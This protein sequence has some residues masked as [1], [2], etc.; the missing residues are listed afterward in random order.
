MAKV[1]KFRVCLGE[2]EDFIWRDIEISSMSSVAKF[3]YAILASFSAVGSHLFGITVHG[4]RYEFSLDDDDFEDGFEE[5]IPPSVVKLASLNLQCG[6]TFAM[7]YD[8]GAGWEFA[9]TLTEASTME[10]GTG[11]RYPHI[12]DGKGN[13]LIEDASPGE[14]LEYIKETDQTGEPPIYYDGYMDC[15]RTWDYREFDAKAL[16]ASFKG[17]I[18]ALQKAYESDSWE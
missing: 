12:T 10:K 13:G 8:Y 6:D 14:L 16:N 9:I 4:R 1:Y 7:E 3:G 18:A 15:E 17:K 5:L 11:S 2:L